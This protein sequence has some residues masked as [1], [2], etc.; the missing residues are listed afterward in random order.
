MQWAWE[1]PAEMEVMGRNARLEYLAK[2]T[3]EQN[4]RQLVSIYD[5]A[6]EELRA[7]HS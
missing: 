7:V 6:M 3:P 5:G 2:Y 4:Y 1:H